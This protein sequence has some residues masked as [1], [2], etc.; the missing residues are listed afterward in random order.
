MDLLRPDL[1]EK[2]NMRAIDVPRSEQREVA[3]LLG[4][5]LDLE[6]FLDLLEFPCNPWTVRIAAAMDQNQD[7]L[8][9]LPAIFTGEPAWRLWQ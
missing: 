4:L 5:A 8:A 3:D 9:L 2:T 1:G 6:P 7:T